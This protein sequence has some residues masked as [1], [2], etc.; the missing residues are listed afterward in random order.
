MPLSLTLQEKY[1]QA[2]VVAFWT[3]LAASGLQIA[4]ARMLE[5]YAPPPPARVLDIGCGA[6]R[7]TLALA[8]RGYAVD[9]LDITAAMV[10][11]AR[12]LA[13]QHGLRAA[14]VQADLC[15]LPLAAGSYDLA[16]IFIAALQH[17]AERGRRRDALRQV[18]LALRPGGVLI[19]ALDN[20]APALRCY[21]AWGTARLRGASN[22]HHSSARQSEPSAPAASTDAVLASNR[23][24]MGRL[25]WH[26]RG[27]ARTLRW[28]TWEG[29]RDSGR[30]LNL[31]PGEPGDTQIEQV[32][33]PPTDGKVYYHLYAHAELMADARIAGLRLLGYHSGNE[34]AQGVAFGETARRLDKQVLY[35][36]QRD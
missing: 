24:R 17:V 19:L 3:Q 16:L 23:T 13:A 14:F 33:M 25:A 10:Q 11:A 26:A 20:V 15:A 21:V 9:G 34:L 6:G 5:R 7:V 22:G 29:L 18:G 8:P 36:F 1:S 30:R 28:R 12:A 2:Q 32:S 31:L 4:E 27:L 35:A